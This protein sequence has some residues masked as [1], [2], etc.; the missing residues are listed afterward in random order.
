MIADRAVVNVWFYDVAFLSHFW[1][2][3]VG[4]YI[5][6]T[7]MHSQIFFLPGSAA[8]IDDGSME[9][10]WPRVVKCGL[11]FMNCTDAV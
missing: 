5:A 11:L 1:V 9:F 2:R 7:F 6:V 8:V 10:P 3:N 4:P